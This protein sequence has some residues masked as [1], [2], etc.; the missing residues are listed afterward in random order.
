MSSVTLSVLAATLHALELTCN[1]SLRKG[2]WSV[3]LTGRGGDLTV[4][5]HDTELVRAVDKAV[6][7][8]ASRFPHRAEA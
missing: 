2:L 7:A 4:I 5:G 8:A 3:F 1:I 6:S